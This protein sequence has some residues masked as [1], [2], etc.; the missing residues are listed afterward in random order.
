MPADTRYW[1][2][3]RG[4][5]F[6][7]KGGWVM[8]KGVFCHGF[9]MNKDLMGR[10]SFFQVLILNATGRLVE[11]PLADWF[12]AMHVGLSWPDARIWC[13]QIG[14]LGGTLR[15]SVVAATVA[16]ILAADSRAYGQGTLLEGFAFI[17]RALAEARKGQSAKDIVAQECARHGGKPKFMGY[18][19]PIAKGD[20]RLAEFY[21]IQKRLGFSIGEHLALALEIE[22]VLLEDFDEAM[23]F[24]GYVSAFLA[25]QGLTAQE[26]YQICAVLVTSGVTACYVDTFERP[27]ESF[28][29][30][31][32]D[33]IDYQGP[34]ARPVPLPGE[35]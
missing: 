6:S 5:I 14:A 11:K 9:E 30:M 25:D 2:E 21:N 12:E 33:D 15:S 23:N 17:E 19:R 20:E 22:K 13:N 32:C 24:N 4:R 3:R 16:G 26:A 31:R 8:G 28:L 29:P 1:D 34:S 18:S 35:P 7:R 27:P 10:V